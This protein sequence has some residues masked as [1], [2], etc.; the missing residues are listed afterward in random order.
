MTAPTGQ[1]L[2]N[3]LGAARSL[4]FGKGQIAAMETLVRTADAEGAGDVQYAARLSLVRAYTHGGEPAKAFVPFAWC[5]AKH[6]QGEGAENW[7]YVLFW[8]FKSV[9]KSLTDFP[10]VPLERTYAVLDDMERR[11]RVAGHTMNPVHQHR[12]IVARHVGDH[13]TAV[14]QYRLWNAAPRGEMSDCAGC[15]PS[16]KVAHLSRYGRFEEAVAI[17]EPVL[18]GTFTCS[19]Q[20]NGILS[21]LLLPFVH[22]GRLEEAARAHRQVYRTIRHNRLDL[23]LLPRHL[24]F[25][26]RTGNHVRGL[27]ILERHLG[28]LDDAPSPYVEMEFCAAAALNLRLV[29]DSGHGGTAVRRP[30]GEISVQALHDELS[31]RAL[32]V[33]ARF[34]ARNGTSEQSDLVRAVLAAEPIVDHLPLSWTSPRPAPARTPAAPSFPDT[35]EELADLAEK[36]SRR[37]EE[38]AA[39][40]AWAKFDEL[41]PEPAG[42]LLARRLSGSAN[43][44][45]DPETAVRDWLRAAE[46]FAAE[47]DEVARHT[48]ASKAGL[49]RCQLGQPGL[50]AL[51]DAAEA[52][53]GLD[54]RDQ[55][56]RALMRWAV[57][58]SETDDLDG[59]SAVL[60]RAEAAATAAP[61]ELTA[62]LSLLRA[63]LT[64]RSGR[65]PEAR[66]LAERATELFAEAGL[67]GQEGW[68]RLMAA[69]MTASTGDLEAAY[70]LLRPAESVA[71]AGLRA[72]MRRTLGMLA[73]DLGLLEDAVGHYRDEVADLAESGDLAGAALAQLGLA[74]AAGRAGDALTAADAAEAAIEVLERDGGEDELARARYLLAGA[75]RALDQRDAALVLLGQVLEHFAAAGNQP[76]AGQAAE[77]IGDVLDELDRDDEAAESYLRAAEC[78]RAAEIPVDAVRNLRQ[79]A[80]SWQWTADPDRA[81]ATL[82]EAE[83]S[84]AALEGDEPPV[85]GERAMVALNGGRILGS[86][87]Q[88]EE[89][90]PRAAA[91]AELLQSIGATTE[92]AIAVSLQ[93]RLLA[94]LDR[95]AEARAAAE[96]A[97]QGFPPEAT[98]QIEG[99]RALLA[100]LDVS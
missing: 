17:A 97:I 26:A 7:D 10:E 82:A 89:A 59:A 72:Q 35:P 58:L 36:H 34:D 4:P 48:A 74:S 46:L 12:Q 94:E 71:D 80:V 39:E 62:R 30:G 88:R 33:A 77:T 67:A 22:S 100:S 56:V 44:A 28:W 63:E 85:V 18:S 9:V 93:A 78:F 70:A 5:L 47:G 11:Y 15:E 76:A 98:E 52:L 14:E 60:G 83:K 99:L 40:A 23:G 2:W 69:R 1:D 29:A 79:A 90:L 73:S 8:S 6:D 65:L 84:A 91:A 31:E 19:E 21:T 3:R 43:A 38:A 41:C 20:P 27:E 51:S 54:D 75:H 50:A 55:Y 32:G 81:L 68:A 86:A 66:E 53:A 57:A 25:C 96:A 45:A 92:A 95:P 61:A 37:G 16:S 24:R 49:A 87:G 13:E 42:A 64:A